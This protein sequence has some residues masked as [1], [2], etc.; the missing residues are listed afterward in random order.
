MTRYRQDKISDG[1]RAWSRQPIEEAAA[2][3]E[4]MVKNVFYESFVLHFRNLA[5]F[6]CKDTPRPDDIAAKDFLPDPSKWIRPTTSPLFDD[7]WER[8]NKE[9]AHLTTARLPEASPDRNWPV[10][11][12][13]KETTQLLKDFIS[14]A[15]TVRLHA[16]VET[17][18]N[19]ASSRSPVTASFPGSGSLVGGTH[20]IF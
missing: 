20:T 11:A 1:S 18:L 19:E 9:L 15:A 4:Q 6:L 14:R 12:L 8:A 10:E 17:V 2:A 3:S 16:S 5:E 7:H 13:L